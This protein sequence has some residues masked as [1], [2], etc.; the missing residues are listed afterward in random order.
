MTAGVHDEPKEWNGMNKG[1]MATAGWRL[2]ALA[3][4]LL[5]VLGGLLTGCGGKKEVETDPAADAATTE[6]LD[7]PVIPEPVEPEPSEGTPLPDYASMAPGEYGVED[8]FF[9]FDEYDIE[10]EYMNVLATDARILREARVP[11][12]IEGHCDERGTV[13]YNL[14]L[15]ERR[16]NAARDYLISLGVPARALETVSYGESRPFATGYG[17]QVWALNRRAHFTRP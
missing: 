9:D 17:E 1:H 14:A 10:P 16:A 3:A 7:A 15:G 13:E 8:V 4:C 5:L 6:E 2:G 12:L 11:V